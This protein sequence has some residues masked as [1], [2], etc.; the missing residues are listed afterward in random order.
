MGAIWVSTIFG[1]VFAAKIAV[2]K[3]TQKIKIE[4]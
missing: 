4:I 3:K 1:A 2:M